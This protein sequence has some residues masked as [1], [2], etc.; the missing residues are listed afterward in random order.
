MDCKRAQALIP[1]YIRK[2]L[3]WRELEEF[4]EHIS[5]CR[6]CYEELEIYFTV[7]YT[8]ARM[9][10]DN[11]DQVYNVSNALKE[12]L[13]ESRFTVWKEKILGISGFALMLA[14]ELVLLLVL[15]AQ[16][17]LWRD[18][19]LDNNPV[20][21]MVGIQQ[22]GEIAPTFEIEKSEEMLHE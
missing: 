9:D 19:T 12:S 6:E 5:H 16:I 20:Y 3:K 18:G 8:L 22:S 11:D 14:A 17:Q 15:F 10:D 4:L 21:R 7:D 1:A 13:Q 2:K